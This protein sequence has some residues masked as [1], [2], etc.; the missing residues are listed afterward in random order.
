[1][2]TTITDEKECTMIN[3]LERKVAGINSVPI[4]IENKS[5]THTHSLTLVSVSVLTCGWAISIPAFGSHFIDEIIYNRCSKSTYKWNVRQFACEFQL[6]RTQ[7]SIFASAYS[8][9]LTF[10][11]R[12]IQTPRSMSCNSHFRNSHLV[13]IFILV[14]FRLAATHSLFYTNAEIWWASK[15]LMN[16]D[17]KYASAN[18]KSAGMTTLNG[19]KVSQLAM[20][21]RLYTWNKRLDSVGHGRFGISGR[22]DTLNRIYRWMMDRYVWAN[23]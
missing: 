23:L 6:M 15:M 16:I 2:G 20:W 17:L 21:L 13:L 12:T 7:E 18:R 3:S 4:G 19:N 22:F 9:I 10:R 11:D 5:A 8:N 1:M 14:H